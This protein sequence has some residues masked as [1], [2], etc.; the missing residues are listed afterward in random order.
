[1]QTHWTELR[2]PETDA[3]AERLSLY[4]DQVDAYRLHWTAIRIR[5][6]DSRFCD[7]SAIAREDLFWPEVRRVIGDLF[8]DLTVGPLAIAPEEYLDAVLKA[9]C[10][11]APREQIVDRLRV[12]MLNEMWEHPVVLIPAEVQ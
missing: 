3:L 12:A 6:V 7:L 9:A 8:E 10:A 4:F 2:T 1:M 11:G 5:I